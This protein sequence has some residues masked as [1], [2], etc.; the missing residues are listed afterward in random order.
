MRFI[1]ALV[2]LAALH[3]PLSGCRSEQQQMITDADSASRYG[4]P[5]TVSQDLLGYDA[6]S[7]SVELFPW[8]PANSNSIGR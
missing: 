8:D 2:V 4:A 3:S 7:K 5:R 1:S 6:K